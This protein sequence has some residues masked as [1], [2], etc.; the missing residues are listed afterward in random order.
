MVSLFF[1]VVDGD[2]RI[3][4]LLSFNFLKSLIITEKIQ[5]FSS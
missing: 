3:F 4:F 1:N 2:G 5:K